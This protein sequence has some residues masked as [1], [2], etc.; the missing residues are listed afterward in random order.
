MLLYTPL[1][2]EEAARA[3]RGDGSPEG[4]LFFVDSP[5]PDEASEDAV[6]VV[7]DLPDHDADAFE[8]EVDVLLGYREFEIPGEHAGRFSARRVRASR[9]VP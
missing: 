6:W 5:Q 8:H 4:A 3:E 2:A 9:D 7:I 1:S